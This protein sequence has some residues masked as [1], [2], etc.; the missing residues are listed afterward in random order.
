MGRL[1]HG[2]WVATEAASPDGAFHRP[3]TTLRSWVTSDGG[4]GPS[5][6]GGY[7]AEAGRYHLYVALAC[8]WAHRTL[9]FRKLKK[10]E[11]LITVSVVEPLMLADG[12]TFSDALPDH[13]GHRKFLRDVYTAAVP[14][15]TGRVTVP[16]LFDKKT[17]TIVNNESAEIIRMFNSAFDKVG[18]DAALDFY[19][20]A[21]RHEIDA[22]N[23]V[24]YD[25]VNNGVYKSGLART[26]AAYDTAVTALF[27]MLDALDGRLAERRYLMGERLTEADWRLFTTLVRF[28]A[29]YFTHFKC[30]L[31]RIADYPNLA[32]YLRELYQMHGIAETVDFDAIRRHYF[33]SHRTINPFGIVPIGPALD[34]HSPHGRGRL[35][36]A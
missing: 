34:L 32:G 22:L 20:H 35:R 11:S 1:E 16:V 4:P 9:I 13:L 25:T 17:S 15:F 3:P 6:S 14:D 31:R 36:A 29:V 28:D 33:Q 12:W 24:V 30:N 7:K 19:P 2:T 21:L 23:A 18:A 10:L 5:G 8:P 27:D 26:Q